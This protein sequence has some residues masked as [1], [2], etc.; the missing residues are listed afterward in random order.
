[1]KED[2][3]TNLDIFEKIALITSQKETETLAQQTQKYVLTFTFL[4]GFS[5]ISAFIGLIIQTF[6]GTR[7]A[8]ITLGLTAVAAIAIVVSYFRKL[9]GMNRKGRKK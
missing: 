8:A 1:M 5:A 9:K 3:K 7:E 4:A 2:S 6:M